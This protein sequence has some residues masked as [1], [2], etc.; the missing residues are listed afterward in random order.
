MRMLAFVLAIICAI[1]AVVYF[2]MPAG[3]LPAFM[4]G[5]VEGSA[6]IHMKHAAI[7]A[8]AA[9]VLFVIGFFIGRR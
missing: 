8:V 2:V 1:V 5:Y 7:A 9:V 4:P 6:H 3:Q